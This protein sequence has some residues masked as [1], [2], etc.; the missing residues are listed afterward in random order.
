MPKCII[1][2]TLLTQVKSS[3]LKGL[4]K[5]TKTHGREGKIPTYVWFLGRLSS[6]I[7]S[8]LP[9][10][11]VYQKVLVMFVPNRVPLNLAGATLKRVFS[12]YQQDFQ[13]PS[14]SHAGMSHANPGNLEQVAAKQSLTCQKKLPLMVSVHLRRKM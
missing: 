9:L 7:P 1:I 8:S 12:H 14:V 4:H 3:D 2:I 10:C 6:V 5:V 13:I 11:S